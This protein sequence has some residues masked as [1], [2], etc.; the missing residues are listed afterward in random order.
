MN[1]LRLPRLPRSIIVR[2]Y[3]YGA[4][5]L[6]GVLGLAIM[7]LHFVRETGRSAELIYNQGM[8]G[9]IGAG[10]LELL[11]EQHRRI[12]ESAPVELDRAKIE[13][14]RLQAE[15]IAKAIERRIAGREAAISGRL[16]PLLPRLLEQA[17][18]VL[19][20]ASNFAQS[21]ALEAVADYSMTANL[22]Q[23]EIRSYRDERL[24]FADRA[25]ENLALRGGQLN[26]WV[27]NTSLLAI[28]LIGPLTFV[29]VNGIGRR[30]RQITETMLRLSANDTSVAVAANEERDEI[31]DM[32]RA[33]A[34]FKANA[35]ALNS[36]RE[37]VEQ[38]NGW[39]DIALNNMAR[40]LTM[41]DA[42]HRLLVCNRR[43]QEMY[44]LP[45][46]LC[47]PGTHIERILAYGFEA[48][49]PAVTGADSGA[50]A[51]QWLARYLELVRSR[52]PFSLTVEMGAERTF[53]VAFQPLE[54][55]GCVAVHE[56]VTEKRLS[57]QRIARLARV[58]TL[59]EVAN[60]LGFREALATCFRDM[61]DGEQLALLW[62]DLDGFKE[63][64]DTH[65][66]PIGD[67][68]LKAFAARLGQCVRRSDHIA[69]LGGDEFAI[70][71]AG[72]RS[73]TEAEALA[74]RLVMEAGRPFEIKGHRIEIGASIGIALAPLHGS[75]PDVL[76]QN[77]DIALYRA[78]AE[79]R[80]RSVVFRTEL[81]ESM[82]ERC[83]LDQALRTALAN[84][85][86][87]LYYQPIVDLRTGRV[88]SCEALM[89]W[90]HPERGMIPPGIFIPLA[91]DNGLIG[92][93]GE[94]SLM[95]AC[96]D[97]ATWPEDVKVAVNLSAVQFASGSLV[98][99]V[100]LA[101]RS[102]G[103]VPQR[104]VLEVTETLLLEDDARTIDMLNQIEGMEVSIALD[105]FGTGYASLSY[106]RSFPFDKIKID[107]TFVRDIEHRED[108]V[109]IVRAVTSLAHTLGMRTVAE[110][111]ETVEHLEKVAGAGCDE[112]QGYLF[113]RPVPAS[114]ISEV[115][116]SCGGRNRCAA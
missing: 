58:D 73:Q 3:A 45:D 49:Q 108:C 44:A 50:E 90:R 5:A 7:S 78:K 86:L 11:L 21:K 32:A 98:D 39:F 97:A 67:A 111:V 41:F 46:E 83:Q 80:G 52:K 38:L 22:A 89:R 65:G 13:R 9:V 57:D 72:C 79:G 12:I 96:R 31:G 43:F 91:E 87:E 18:N 110:G 14:D 56:D 42:D 15:D 66:H 62:I 95:R 93:I 113:S 75:D 69:R 94:W 85:E 1:R 106:L 64:N 48:G 4:V 63:V 71:Q 76:L 105:D 26:R 74:R 102:S 8:I 17:H 10:D 115:I 92:E 81:A 36:E 109:A 27:I 84:D 114:E 107:Q 19:R 24:A 34:V 28:V 35:I 70:L 25:L 104:L 100:Q 77:A 54:D 51:R 16:A 29:V 23:I 59:T 55:G 30:I 68:L 103:L 53:Q 40:G 101:L 33:V 82:R 112:V 88:T 20:L 6:A 2:L 60:R 61:G 47:R 116:R 99:A 37:K